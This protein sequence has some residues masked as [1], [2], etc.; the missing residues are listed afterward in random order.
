MSGLQFGQSMK[1]LS[2]WDFAGQM[3][4]VTLFLKGTVFWTLRYKEGDKSFD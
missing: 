3:F 2:V 1:I 4:W